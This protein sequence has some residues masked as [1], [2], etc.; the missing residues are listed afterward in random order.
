MG[1]VRDITPSVLGNGKFEG[2]MTFDPGISPD[3]AMR[4][5]ARVK[6]ARICANLPILLG[7]LLPWPSLVLA[8]P[9][10]GRDSLTDGTVIIH[11]GSILSL[12]LGRKLDGRAIQPGSG[13]WNGF[14][15]FWENSRRSGDSTVFS[16]L[17][18]GRYSVWALD[19][20]YRQVYV[21]F[22]LGGKDRRSVDARTGGAFTGKIARATVEDKV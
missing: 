4:S 16:R 17:P 12:K 1:D 14:E 22:D 19:S 15:M 7:C 18:P 10:P 21:S 2:S 9:H 5:A 20:A 8:Q 6:R 11:H 13:R 3:E